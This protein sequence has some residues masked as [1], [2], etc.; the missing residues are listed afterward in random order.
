VGNEGKRNLVKEFPDLATGSF[1]K[2]LRGSGGVRLITSDV[3]RQ[4]R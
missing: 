2:E 4:R 1:D 3:S